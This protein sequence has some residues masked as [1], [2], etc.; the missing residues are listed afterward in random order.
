MATRQSTFCPGANGAPCRGARGKPAK[1]EDAGAVCGH[2]ARRREVSGGSAQHSKQAAAQASRAGDHGPAP[3]DDRAVSLS[4]LSE[5]LST[6][7]IGRQLH[8]APL[9]EIRQGTHG[10]S[11]VTVAELGDKGQIPTGALEITDP[12]AASEQTRSVEVNGRDLHDAINSYA[13]AERRALTAADISIAADGTVRVGEAEI[14][15]AD[16]E[17]QRAAEAFSRIKEIRGNAAADGLTMQHFTDQFT[18]TPMKDCGLDDYETW[19]KDEKERWHDMGPGMIPPT[20]AEFDQSIREAYDHEV[21]SLVHRFSSD[22]SAALNNATRDWAY[23]H[24]HPWDMLHDMA[25]SADEAAAM[26]H[27]SAEQRSGMDRAKTLLACVGPTE[28]DPSTSVG[29]FADELRRILPSVGKDSK[30]ESL[31]NVHFGYLGGR[32]RMTATDTYQVVSSSV[33]TPVALSTKSCLLPAAELG[34]FA[35]AADKHLRPAESSTQLGISEGAYEVPDGKDPRSGEPRTKQ[36]AAVALHSG[37]MRVAMDRSPFGNYPNGFDHLFEQVKESR[38]VTVS[39]QQLLEAAGAKNRRSR[40]SQS[41]RIAL[42]LE[43]TDSGTV[44]GLRWRTQFEQ[45]P[46]TSGVAAAAT[47]TRRGRVDDSGPVANMAPER[48]TQGLRFAAAQ[49]AN[50]EVR[51][52][53][54]GPHPLAIVPQGAP[55]SPSDIDRIALVMPIRS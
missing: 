44:A 3:W 9:V 38:T 35:K 13:A 29:E 5:V 10:T 40:G 32:H 54:E 34:T 25:H 18:A 36:K 41:D 47:G 50:V 26:V 20:E 6:A 1:V 12:A 49:E 8:L 21:S 52:W 48:L 53:P 51:G 37:Q 24:G 27:V 55:R 7:G 46:A 14:L 17:A 15:G 45:T 33:G 30:R 28:W 16:G 11:F 23:R 19:A 4:E 22:A 31:N 39:A 42:S 43:R 2:C